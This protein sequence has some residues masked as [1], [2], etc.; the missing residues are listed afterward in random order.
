MAASSPVEVAA[1]SA[2]PCDSA[3]AED[4]WHTLS[5]SDVLR[6]LAVRAQDGL[7]E[8]Q[9]EARR[10]VHGPNA[11]P[12]TP[13]RPV[14]RL[15]ARQLAS[16]LIYI[17]FAAALMAVALAHHGDVGVILAVVL[18][19]ALIGTFQEG[20]AERS[21]AALRRLAA[22]QMRV[23]RNGRDSMVEARH[24]VPGDILLLTAGD[25]I[26][27]D[28]RLLEDAQL[29]AAEAALTG[30]SVPVS[31]S[32]AQLLEATGLA[33]RRNMVYS[34]TYL[35][36]GRGIG[37]VVATGPHTEVGRIAGLTQDAAEPQTP[38]QERIGQFGRVLVAAAFALFVLVVVLG[39]WRELPLSE[40]LMVA[41]SQMV[42]MVP[43]GLPVAMTI[44]LAVGM[45]RMA[46]RGVI[47]RRRWLPCWKLR[48]FAT[49]RRS[50]HRRM[51][52]VAGL[53]WAIPPKAPCWCSR[54]KPE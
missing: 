30:E 11:L 39:V 4:R 14:W 15:F 46:A 38:L 42:S 5:A 44:A 40:V 53:W 50:C 37:V 47:I 3:S 10:S 8:E 35:T 9:I 21:M 45:Q 17:L 34:G 49:M 28:A 29:Q 36:A 1:L 27:A 6:R 43:E 18:V 31:K 7:T 48:C 33:D 13:P 26:A 51:A 19:N 22:V 32:A 25:A 12:E 23:L 2:D 16:P 52:A 54:P 20:R 24:L 41:I